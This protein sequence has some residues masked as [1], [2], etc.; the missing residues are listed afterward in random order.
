M[1]D[2]I[3]DDELEEMDEDTL[4]MCIVY[5]RMSTNYSTGQENVILEDVSDSDVAYLVEHKTE[6]PGFD[7]DF[8]G[9]KRGL[10]KKK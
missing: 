5:Q 9:W 2:R 8:G 6:F 1:Y 10:V 4:K 3:G 7:V